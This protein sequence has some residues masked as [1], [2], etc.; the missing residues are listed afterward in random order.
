MYI[1][2]FNSLFLSYLSMSSSQASALQQWENTTAQIKLVTENIANLKTEESVLGSLI[3]A[4]GKNLEE[5]LEEDKKRLVSFSLTYIAP[6]RLKNEKHTKK[7]QITQYGLYKTLDPKIQSYL[8]KNKLND[9][10]K[11]RFAQSDPVLIQFIVDGSILYAPTLVTSTI[12]SG[13][14]EKLK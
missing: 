10:I 2:F 1:S 4:S 14:K 11:I 12:D 5:L 6:V 3:N 9:K 8:E 7:R 13:W